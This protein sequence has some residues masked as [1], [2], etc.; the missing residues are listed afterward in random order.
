MSMQNNQKISFINTYHYIKYIFE[1]GRQRKKNL[2][3]CTILET[4]CPLTVITTSI[5]SEYRV[6]RCAHSKCHVSNAHAQ[7]SK[8]F[9]YKYLSLYKLHL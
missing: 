2:W 7:E 8:Y 6:V 4:M 9:F 3:L 1:S 5:H